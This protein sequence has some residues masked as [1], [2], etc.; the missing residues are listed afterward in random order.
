MDEVRE[1]VVA[2]TLVAG[3]VVRVIEL[4]RKKPPTDNDE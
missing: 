1:W 3:L 4:R 2:L